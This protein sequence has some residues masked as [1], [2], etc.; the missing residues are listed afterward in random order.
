VRVEISEDAVQELRRWAPRTGRPGLL[1]QPGPKHEHYQGP[2][3]TNEDESLAPGTRWNFLGVGEESFD[4]L[5]ATDPA[6]VAIAECGDFRVLVLFPPASGVLRVRLVDGFV[7][8][9]EEDA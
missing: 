8:I 6:L 5:P 4:N 7:T 9:D 1:I 3:W 2:E